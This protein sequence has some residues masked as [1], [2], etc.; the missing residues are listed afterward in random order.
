M[1]FSFGGKHEKEEKN[2]FQS[3][4]LMVGVF[5]IHRGLRRAL[6]ALIKTFINRRHSCLL[7]S[8]MG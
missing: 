1:V 3:Y 8:R 4:M 5:E 6:E 7:D 2:G